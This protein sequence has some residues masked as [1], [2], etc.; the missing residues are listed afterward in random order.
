MVTADFDLPLEPAADSL[1]TGAGDIHYAL[2]IKRLVDQTLTTRQTEVK[3]AFRVVTNC[4][5]AVTQ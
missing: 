1:A 2:S 5:L 3:G 4:L